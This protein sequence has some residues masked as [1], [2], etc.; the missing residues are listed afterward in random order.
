MSI[1][2]RRG[3]LVFWVILNFGLSI[4]GL[5]SACFRSP[6]S[7]RVVFVAV[8]FEIFLRI[9]A[10][11]SCSRPCGRSIVLGGGVGISSENGFEM[12]S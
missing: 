7:T 6:L 4:E 3:D 5:N 10:K 2:V 9:A 11:S 8:V 1:F 12:V